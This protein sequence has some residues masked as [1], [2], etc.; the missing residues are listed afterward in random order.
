MKIGVDFDGTICEREGIPRNS[1]ITNEK[2]IKYAKEAIE[3]LMREG[4][5]L[6]I[7]STRDKDEILIWLKM[8][9]FPL[10]EIT[11]KKIPGTTAYIDDRAIRFE[12]NWQSICKL[13]G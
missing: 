9:N 4:H 7:F 2:P 6:Y 1:G 5:E 10:L 11:D 3:W 12:N 13:F 8:N